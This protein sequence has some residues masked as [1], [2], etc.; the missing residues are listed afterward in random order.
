[1]SE[2]EAMELYAGTGLA[3]DLSIS[4]PPEVVLAEARKA[5]K[6]LQDVISKKTDPVIFGGQ[7][8]LEFED[9]ATC[10]RFYGVTAKVRETRF[11]QYGDVVGFEA[12]ADAIVTA[13]GQAISSADAMCLNDE[14]KW[15]TRA[16]Y[17]WQE[18]GGKKTKVKV[19]DVPVPL[20]Q[21]RSMAQTR[22]CAKALRNVF[23]WVVVLAGYRPTPA[24]EMTNGTKESA[25]A[26]EMSTDIISDAQRKRFF[27]KTKASSIPEDVIKSR[28]ASYHYGS[29]KEIK[30]IHYDALCEWA[31]GFGKSASIPT[32]PEPAP[33]GDLPF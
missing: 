28:L 3:V 31:D 2:K 26:P 29:T 7:Q 14:D 19:G 18:V 12:S 21:L 1:M 9:W 27:A 15:S 33:G 6:A 11:I 23:S 17:E 24:E 22:A 20:F 32:N 8:Y 10:A 25:P 13:S 16:K 5:A 30:R 4:R